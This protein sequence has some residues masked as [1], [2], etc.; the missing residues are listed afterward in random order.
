LKLLDLKSI[1]NSI[2]AMVFIPSMPYTSILYAEELTFPRSRAYK[3]NDSCL[4]QKNYLI[5][6][7]T[8][9]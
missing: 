7:M 3:K 9:G 8:V 2:V 4:E 6:R 5:V 1:P